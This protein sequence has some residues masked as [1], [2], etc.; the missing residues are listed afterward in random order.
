MNKGKE[1][2]PTKYGIFNPAINE[3]PQSDRYPIEAV[4]VEKTGF[5]PA[6]P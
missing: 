6:T 3:Q 5:E 1:T 4:F 2:K